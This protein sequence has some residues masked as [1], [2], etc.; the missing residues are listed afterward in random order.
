MTYPLSH[1]IKLPELHLPS[2]ILKVEPFVLPQ[3]TVDKG[4]SVSLPNIILGKQAEFLFS[5]TIKASKHFTIVAENVQINQEKRTLGELDYILK[6]Q[7]TNQTNHV[8]LACKFYLLKED[9]NP[10][11]E[12]QWIGP[13]LKDTLLDKINKFKAHQFPLLQHMAT[14]EILK[15]FGISENITQHYCIKAKL[16]VP[17]HYAE[18]I[19]KYYQNCIKGVWKKHQTLQL[20]KKASYAIPSKREWL[21]PES[22]ITEWMSSKK[23]S[24]VIAAQINQKKSSHVYEKLGDQ[25]SSF[26]VVWW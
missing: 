14:K 15:T 17:E 24:E 1:F 18:K 19:P 12:G 9:E 23:I 21:L 16:F 3:V 4:I 2:E 5:E 7:V 20:N 8:E 22:E 6:N 13:N 11:L 25:I 26:F 10:Q